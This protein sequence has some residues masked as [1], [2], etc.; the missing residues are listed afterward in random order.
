M[1]SLDYPGISLY[2]S[3]LVLLLLGI[4]W[5]GSKYPWKSAEVLATIVIGAILLVL[6]G[7]WGNHFKS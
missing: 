4:S 6:F 7:L 2:I 3:G 1:K 5:G